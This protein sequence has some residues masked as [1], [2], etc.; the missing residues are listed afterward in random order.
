MIFLNTTAASYVSGEN[1]N[2]DGGT[3]SALA[4]G[5]LELDYLAALQ[6]DEA[7]EPA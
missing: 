2:T 5:R 4:T 6:P 1:V 7:E 3:V